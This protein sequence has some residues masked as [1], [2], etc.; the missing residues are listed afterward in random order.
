LKNNLLNYEKEVKLKMNSIY[1]IL[2][3]LWILMIVDCVRH[4]PEKS[5]WLFVL[6]SLNF[7]GAII[8]LIV[9]Y[10]PQNIGHRAYGN[11]KFKQ[12]EA[13]VNNIGKAYQYT[14]LGDILL[15]RGNF[16]EAMMAY[17]QALDKEPSNLDAL[18][19]ISLILFKTK[20]LDLAKENLQTLLKIEDSFKT[21][22]AS[23]LYGKVLFEMEDWELA[24]THLENDIKHWNHPE[25]SLMLA[26]IL[27]QQ[28]QHQDAY[29]Y[30]KR[31]V[32]TVKAAPLFHYKRHRQ[33]VKTGERL[34][35]K[36][37]PYFTQAG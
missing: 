21:G 4:E 18:W 15:D 33:V 28:E 23:F 25:S 37:T 24:K 17:Q 11:Q 31:M 32:S 8:Y 3:I 9:R 26:K 34:L 7:V 6:F 14:R 2:T 22:D 13:D 30:L 5:F 16:N 29:Q 19:G 20:Q 27:I 35:K 12:A 36:L 10:L 1:L